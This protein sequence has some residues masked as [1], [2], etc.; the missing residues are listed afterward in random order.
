MRRALLAVSLTAFVLLRDW[1]RVL[2]SVRRA[3]DPHPGRPPGCDQLLHNGSSPAQ[4]GMLSDALF[5]RL[6]TA[7]PVRGARGSCYEVDGA[8]LCLPTFLVVGFTKAGTTAL[9]RYLAQHPRV[10]VSLFLPHSK[11]KLPGPIPH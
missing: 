2:L 6:C 5:A 11:P 10:R 1:D 3:R 7:A 4:G 9:F 8:T